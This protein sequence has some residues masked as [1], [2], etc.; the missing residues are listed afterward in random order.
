MYTQIL[1]PEW[2]AGLRSWI[3]GQTALKVQWM[4]RARWIFTAVMSSKTLAGRGCPKF[5]GLDESGC[6]LSLL[7]RSDMSSFHPFWSLAKRECYKQPPNLAQV[8][9]N[10]KAKSNPLISKM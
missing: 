9:P 6:L 8:V 7:R 4:L 3:L 10:A 5:R 2:C 1:Q